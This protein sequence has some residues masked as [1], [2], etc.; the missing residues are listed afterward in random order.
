MRCPH[1]GASVPRRAAACPECGSDERTGWAAEDEIDY[2]SF[3]IPD[4]YDPEAWE[5]EAEE[6]RGRAGFRLLVVG[7]I[8]LAL[9][10]VLGGLLAHVLR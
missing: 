2:Q 6:R 10:G 1:C 5:S 9:V 8:V 7:L 3:E 4:A